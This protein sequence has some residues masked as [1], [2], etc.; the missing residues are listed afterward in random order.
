MWDGILSASNGEI[1]EKYNQNIHDMHPLPE[2]QLEAESLFFK[3][4]FPNCDKISIK[5]DDSLHT[6][7]K[8]S[9]THITSSCPDK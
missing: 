1:I 3:L 6:I 8:T 9:L 7:S 2:L 5:M 4:S